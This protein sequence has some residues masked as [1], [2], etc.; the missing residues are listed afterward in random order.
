MSKE[1]MI[2]RLT[3]MVAIDVDPRLD[4]LDLELLL[5]E[6]RKVDSYGRS[7]TD[8]DWEPTYNLNLAASKGWDIKAGKCSNRFNF[9]SD[10]NSMQR[11][12][13]F[14]HCIKMS[15]RYRNRNNTTIELAIRDDFDPVIG[16][17]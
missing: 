16:N 15:D 5:Q 13:V 10:V 9:S 12:Q 7:W 17:L 8:V 1:V 4:A 6:C 2:A 14:N 11:E 3:R